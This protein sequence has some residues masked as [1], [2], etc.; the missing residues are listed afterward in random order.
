MS[1]ITREIQGEL[2]NI[3]PYLKGNERLIELFQTLPI[4]TIEVFNVTAENYANRKYDQVNESNEIIPHGFFGILVEEI[5]Y[6]GLISTLKRYDRE[7]NLIA[8]TMGMKVSEIKMLIKDIREPKQESIIE[9]ERRMKSQAEFKEIIRKFTSKY[10][11]AYLKRIIEERQKLLLQ[12]VEFNKKEKAKLPVAEFIKQITGSELSTELI[13]SYV[14][15]KLGIRID[16]SMIV[17]LIVASF[18][19]DYSEQIQSILNLKFNEPASFSLF[20]SNRN[21]N[22]LKNNYERKLNNQMKDCSLEEK[23]ALLKII[24]YRTKIKRTN[25]NENTPEFNQLKAIVRAGDLLLS[26]EISAVMSKCDDCSI[27]LKDGKFVFNIPKVLTRDECRQCQSYLKFLAY[28]KGVHN[29]IQK[30]YAHQNKNFQLVASNSSEYYFS[31]EQN[32]TIDMTPWFN[33]D[34]IV[35]L[36]S[37][38]NVRKI[39]DLSDEDFKVLKELLIN[40]GLLWA[41]LADN[42]ELRD[43]AAIINNFEY[44]AKIAN[45]ERLTSENLNEIIKRANLYSYADEVLIGLIGIDNV[46]KIINYNQFSGVTVT[47]EVIKKRLNKVTDLAVRSERYKYSSLPFDCSI[48]LGEYTLSRYANNDPAVFT[49]GVD[50]KTCFFVGVNEND[51]FFYSLIHKDGYIIKITNEKDELIGRASCFRKNNVF[52]INGIRL[53]NNKVVPE[54]Q[55]E[56]KELIKIV[57]LVKLMAQKMINMTKDDE[58]PI[59][60]VVC[61]RAGILENAYFEERFERLNPVLFNEPVNV[62][63]QEWQDFVHMYDKEP[64]QLLLEVPNNPNHSFTTDFGDHYPALLIA[65]RDFRGLLSPRDIEIKDQPET[66]RRPRLAPQV[67]MRDEITDDILARINR[68]RALA[69]FNDKQDRIED[70]KKKYHLINNTNDIESIV[71]GDDWVIIYRLDHTVNTYFA[72]DVRTS[73]VEASK[74]LNQRKTDEQGVKLYFI[75]RSDQNKS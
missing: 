72:N 17:R 70:N 40:K 7:I 31:Q 60:Y 67:Y 38:L 24:I 13:R 58:C 73:M 53:K 25:G 43:M 59:D 2:D 5:R 57:E 61:N 50:T 4:P 49:S 55:E 69:C 39:L 42:L 52:M 3:R 9:R 16:N 37:K 18:Q 62:Y 29:I 21:G 12:H 1:E 30:E 35:K 15:K 14:Q 20:T 19:P 44:I 27:S 56:L 8:E 54:N 51:F 34:K 68:I 33:C 75:P 36:L 63:S 23:E 74:Y 11:E 10:K 41:Y 64:E 32:Y 45:I 48:K 66:Y 6:N 46:S 71:L 47:D 65:S 26:E 28:I 22:R